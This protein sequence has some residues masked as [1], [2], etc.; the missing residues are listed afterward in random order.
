MGTFRAEVDDGRMTVK[1]KAGN[2]LVMLDAD[3]AVKRDSAAP[4]N[5]MMFSCAEHQ[6]FTE[7]QLK[8]LRPVLR[9]WV[10]TVRYILG[11]CADPVAYQCW[12]REFKP[13]MMT[14]NAIR[15]IWGF[16]IYP[17]SLLLEH[18]VPLLLVWQ[19]TRNVQAY[20]ALVAI[21]IEQYFAGRVKD[22]M[23]KVC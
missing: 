2:V 15:Y 10:Q 3:T 11:L 1:G 14:L 17:S 4:Y 22:D 20:S 23:K 7:A 8:L 19:S 12:M 6:C 9:F 21:G 5:P 18:E 13:R 16:I